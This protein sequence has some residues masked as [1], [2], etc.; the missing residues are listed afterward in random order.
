MIYIPNEELE[1]GF[2]D[3]LDEWHGIKESTMQETDTLREISGCIITN[4]G[5]TMSFPI[6]AIVP[7]RE[8]LVTFKGIT[9]NILLVKNTVN[10]IAFPGGNWRDIVHDIDESKVIVGE[11]SIDFTPASFGGTKVVDPDVVDR[12]FK[13]T[14]NIDVVHDDPDVTEITNSNTLLVLPV[15]VDDGMLPE[16]REF[17]DKSAGMK[18]RAMDWLAT[19]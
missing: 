18:R 10:V 5:M 2:K 3:V 6:R 11:I 8:I 16:I 19:G 1:A 9:R 15:P 12:W 7:F 4:P 17:L 14:F 13:A